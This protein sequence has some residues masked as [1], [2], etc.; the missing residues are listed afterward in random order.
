MSIINQIDLPN[1]F[2]TFEELKEDY[3]DLE[4]SDLKLLA[5]SVGTSVVTFRVQSPTTGQ[6]RPIHGIYD[7]DLEL[8]LKTY[9]IPKATDEIISS[10]RL[11]RKLKA[12][13]NTL[14]KYGREAGLL[15]FTYDF[16]N[17]NQG[18][19][20][21]QEQ[22][23]IVTNILEERRKKTA[24]K[25]IRSLNSIRIDYTIGR[26]ALD[27]MLEDHGIDAGEYYFGI[28]LGLGLDKKQ[29]ARIKPALDERRNVDEKSTFKT[30]NNWREELKISK[31]F[32]LMLAEG[33][34]VSTSTKYF[35]GYLTEGF[36][37]KDIEA[38][39]D[40]Y[41]K[42]NRPE[43]RPVSITSISK[44]RKIPSAEVVRLAGEVGATPYRRLSGR[45]YGMSIT[46]GELANL[47]RR[48]GRPR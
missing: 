41:E 48:F 36:S 5:Q 17:G 47:E 11:G 12:D 40:A 4:L 9:E 35:H 37:R 23:E 3:P 44:A 27:Q 29:F 22:E 21:S 33:A 32:L 6:V 26:V 20:F 42:F 16:G 39:A 15:L 46:R 14:I 1:N 25:D 24:G 8:I 10:Y 31:R 45:T 28:S 13:P 34:G 2:V 18:I 43:N 7:D 38:I 19:G 30:V